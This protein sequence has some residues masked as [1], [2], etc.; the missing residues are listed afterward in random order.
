MK[1]LIELWKTN[2]EHCEAVKPV[3]AD[4]EKEGYAIEKYNIE[5]TDGFTLVHDYSNE[6]D[7]WNKAMKYD[8]GYIYTPT[9]INPRT[10]T[11]LSF[12]DR[13][14]TREELTKLANG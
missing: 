14:P 2:C 4:L 11:I 6:I 9:F 3:V 5:E 8:Q 12:P 1:K 13:E 7:A 10:R